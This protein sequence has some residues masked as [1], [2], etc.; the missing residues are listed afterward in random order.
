MGLLRAI[1]R[2]GN[3]Q[4]QSIALT[5]D[6]GPDPVYTGKI[7]DIL[8]K[9]KIKATFFVTGKKALEH[10]E[11]VKRIFSK[12]HE[13]GNHSFSHKSLIFKSASFIRKEIE[14]TDEILRNLGIEGNIHFRPPYGRML[15]TTFILLLRLRKKVVLWDNNPKD[16]KC[17]SSKEIVSKVLKKLKQGSIIVLHDGAK[18][19]TDTVKAIEILIPEL[20]KRDYMFK[21]ISELII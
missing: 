12:G 9:N 8:E 6:D 11:L 18:N 1:I 14:Q 21:T 19:R 16:Y 4:E 3:R 5:F 17:S 7:L 20:L 10:P 2:H 13:V 15:L